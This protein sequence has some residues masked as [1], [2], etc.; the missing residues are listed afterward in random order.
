MNFLSNLKQKPGTRFLPHFYSGLSMLQKLTVFIIVSLFATLVSAAPA[1]KAYATYTSLDK[2]EPITFDGEK[3]TWQGKSFTLDENTI[4]LDYRLEESQISNNPYAFNNIKDAVA[5]LKNGTEDNPMMMLTAPGVY[6]VDDPDDPEIRVPKPGEYFPVGMSI[7]CN[8]LYFYGLNTNPDN[9]VFAVNR[10][11]TQGAS[12]NFTMFSIN[13]KG[14]KSENV[15]FGN[16]C[17]VDLEFPLAPKLNREKRAEA[18]AQAQ[19]FMYRSRDGV[20]VNTNFISRLNLLPFAMTYLNCHLESSGHASFFNSVYIGCSFKLY[21]VNF[22]SGKFFDCDIYLT[23]F[24]SNYKNKETYEFGFVDGRGNGL[25]CVN[26]RFHRS[27]DLVDSGISAEVSWDRIPQSKTTRSYQYNVTL[28][29]KPYVIQE[30]TTPG[31]T[32]VIKE[33]SELLKAYQLQYDNKTYY[34][35]PNILSGIDPFNYTNKV[36]AAAVADGKPENYYLSIPMALSLQ[37]DAKSNSTIRS[38]QTEA[39]LLY[40]ILPAEYAKSTALGEWLFSTKNPS[41]A[42]YVSIADNKNGTITVAGTN[43]TREA[44]DVII[45]ARNTLGIEAAFELTIEPPY[46]DA[47]EFM[48]EPEITKPENGSVKLDYKLNLDGLEDESLI[49]WYRCN[50]TNDS[51]PLK[52]SVTRLNNPENNYNLSKGDAGYYLKAVIQPKHKLCEPGEETTIYSDF[53]VA[54]EDVKTNRINT[55]FHN[56]PTDPQPAILPGT[57]TLDGYFAPEC[58]D[59]D[60]NP[61]K[62]RYEPNNDSWKFALE[63]RGN[64]EYA[65]LEQSKRGAR[66]FYTQAGASFGNMKLKASFAPKK[67]SGAGFGSATDQFLDVFIK[68]DLASMSGYALRIERLS[69]TEVNDLGF[70]GD[71]AT[72]GCAFSLIKY[73]KGKTTLLTKKMMSSAFV[74]ESLVDMKVVDGKLYA[75]VTSTKKDRSGDRYKYPREVNLDAEINENGF[76]GTGMLFTGTTGS[77][78]VKVLHWE[79]EWE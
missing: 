38:T 55:N 27:K 59:D 19:L 57:W 63:H 32:V 10:G 34:N 70:D 42:Q 64:E 75:S 33:D 53:K 58:Y 13:G 28:D 61:P 29:G 78:A 52:V 49:T 1:K 21:N 5:A 15:T 30:Y 40:K 18:I 77:N 47:P 74:T 66:L 23:P 7:T 48:R 20:A 54:A 22:A 76:G 46:T 2:T 71:G 26:T 8:H 50:D 16:F 56:L 25:V 41:N 6:W 43:K 37:L 17:N 62:P 9:V 14:L 24:T 67:T 39:I 31:A 65:G 51:N 73:E 60:L 69:T 12:G 35:V 36:K 72:A 68:F 3:V 4:F 79:T 44:V 11:Q 45:V